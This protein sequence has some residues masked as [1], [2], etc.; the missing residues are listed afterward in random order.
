MSRDG[1]TQLINTKQNNAGVKEFSLPKNKI[2]NNVA[3]LGSSDSSDEYSSEE[4]DE[5]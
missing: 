5:L 4:S 2:T 3:I 1:T